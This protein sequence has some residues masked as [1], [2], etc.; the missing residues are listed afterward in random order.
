V[1]T[2][3]N[4]TFVVQRL[5]EGGADCIRIGGTIDQSFTAQE[6]GAIAGP[7]AIELAEVTSITS[8]G[9]EAWCSFVKTVPSS[10]SLQLFNVPPCFATQI[11]FV[12]NFAGSA[13]IVTVSA[14]GKCTSC[15]HEQH[16]LVD[17][18]SYANSGSQLIERCPKCGAALLPVD[19]DL[20][21]L[22]SRRARS[23]APELA[24]LLA[25]LGIY[26]SRGPAQ[27]PLEM[28]KLVVG[29]ANLL[30]MSG[31]LDERLRPQRVADGLEG[32]LLVETSQLDVS[33]RGVRRFSEMVTHAARHCSP[34]VMVGLPYGVLEQAGDVLI[35]MPQL[36][37]HS[38]VAPCYCSACD[39]IRQL[40][41]GGDELLVDEPK[42]ACPRCGRHAPLV[43]GVLS[44]ERIR[45]LIRPTPEGLLEIIGKFNELFSVAE[46]EAKLT[47][48]P[49]G[50]ANTV[51][52]RIGP[53]RIVRAIAR[54]G[55]ADVF[56]A[57]RDDFVKPV[58]LKLLRR[59]VLAQASVSLSMFLREARLNARL[60]HPNIVQVFDVNEAEGNLYIVMEYLDGH[61]LWRLF[62]QNA[63]PFPVPIALRIA[64]QVLR[65]LHH[66]HT[67]RDSEGQPLAIVHR[68][69]SPSNIIVC[70]DGNVKLID[71][72]IAVAGRKAEVFAGNPAWM[73]PEQFRSGPLD[74]RSDLFSVATVLH[75]LLTGRQ[76]FTGKTVEEIAVH[77]IRAEIP[78]IPGIPPAL[79]S[80]L[81]K[82]HQRDPNNR[83]QTAGEFADALR[84]VFDGREEASEHDVRA[85]ISTV[86]SRSPGTTPSTAHQVV[87]LPPSH[88]RTIPQQQ[89][90][91]PTVHK[92]LEE[93]GASLTS[94][95]VTP[96]P[97]TDPDP[98]IPDP[99]SGKKL[100]TVL[101]LLMLAL[102][103][104]AL[105]TS[106][107]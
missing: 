14:Q 89:G 42:A 100:L 33:T 29:N 71:F 99:P 12:P 67:A 21:Q 31:T 97:K 18:M 84:A 104:I 106:V 95:S 58:A 65:A 45:P 59:E 32:T 19:V 27:T 90:T 103:G 35:T 83:Y 52:Q 16:M 93:V 101:V 5:S 41:I 23:L 8:Q 66:A 73:S 62:K 63:A 25:K 82:A 11:E 46:V 68:D 1:R 7:T 69:V 10:V 64:Q 91:P 86:T 85:F 53:Y 50:P 44:L 74:G 79:T 57:T 6:I 37:L 24:G 107:Q 28:Q 40:S 47:N 3:R 38:I 76:L 51:P 96:A 34:I 72:G 92:P 9:V 39:E 54:G 4:K 61:A 87:S 43:A 80:V 36:I 55:M 17:M 60:N 56:L 13:E 70:P 98:E 49:V 15:T 2:H 78:A 81:Q 20:T 22:A 30:R 48:A 88:Q 94:P 102:T 105:L 75:E 77:V 26:R